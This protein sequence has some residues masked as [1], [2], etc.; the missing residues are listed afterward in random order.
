MLA[1]GDLKVCSKCRLELNIKMFHRNRAAKDGLGA[2]C[3]KCHAIANKSTKKTYRINHRDR[4]ISRKRAYR[5]QNIDKVK[6]TYKIYKRS[7]SGRYA[8]LKD[9]A[10]QRNIDITITLDEYSAFIQDKR[11]LYCDGSL[12]ECGS[13]LDR[14][15]NTLGYTLHNVNPCCTDCNYVRG[16]RFT[17]QEMIKYIGPAVKAAKEDR[18]K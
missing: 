11:C 1:K 16:N 6:N 12:P 5:L 15:D 14:I 4:V 2:Y 7:I 8:A 17:A 10:N 9:Q 13:G 3:K 18:A